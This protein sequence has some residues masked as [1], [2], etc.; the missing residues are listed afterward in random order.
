MVKQLDA[1]PKRK[2]DLRSFYDKADLSI[3]RIGDWNEFEKSL[4]EKINHL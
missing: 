2:V 4:S 1:I 3:D